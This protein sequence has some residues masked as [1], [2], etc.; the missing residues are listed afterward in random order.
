MKDMS[1]S[2]V[3]SCSTGIT[4]DSMRGAK[5]NL[6]ST[7]CESSKKVKPVETIES[8]EAKLL[9]DGPFWGKG[10]W[11]MREVVSVSDASSSTPG[12]TKSL[13]QGQLT[14]PDPR[15]IRAT[16]ANYLTPT[17]STAYST[18]SE[19]IAT[20]MHALDDLLVSINAQT[21]SFTNVV[22]RTREEAAYRHSRA[23]SNARKIRK[24]GREFLKGFK[25]TVA[26]QAKVGKMNAKEVSLLMKDVAEG[27]KEGI[28]DSLKIKRREAGKQ[29]GEKG[30]TQGSSRKSKRAQRRAERV[31]GRR[32]CPEFSRSFV[33]FGRRVEC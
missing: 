15:S 8:S 7:E 14:L 25:E 29:T 1:L 22:Y 10:K 20:L 23:K 24:Q 16:I 13:L 27:M 33:F 11:P 5:R 28:S 12:S 6:G 19:D 31:G 18:V 21:T 2:V 32:V 3:P 17:H 30:V 26:K 9:I 4:I